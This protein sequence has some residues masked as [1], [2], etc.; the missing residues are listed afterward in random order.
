MIKLTNASPSFFD[1]SILLNPE[2]FISVYSTLDSDG[3]V[4]TNIYSTTKE[5]WVVSETVEEIYELIKNEN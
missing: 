4:I 5:N 1:E 2:F 3:C